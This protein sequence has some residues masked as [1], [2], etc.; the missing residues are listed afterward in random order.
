M[1]GVV[2]F[3]AIES[4]NVRMMIVRAWGEKREQGA[5]IQWVQG[6]S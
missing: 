4:K 6:F 3:I 1:S 5:V 2:K